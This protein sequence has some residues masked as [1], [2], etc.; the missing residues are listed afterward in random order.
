MKVIQLTK[1]DKVI[2]EFNSYKDYESYLRK[3]LVG[4]NEFIKL[5]EKS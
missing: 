4:E 3:G 1:D 5:K 2:K